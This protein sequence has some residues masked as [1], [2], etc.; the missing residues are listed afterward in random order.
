MA[1]ASV[2]ESKRTEATGEL[3]AL[4]TGIEMTDKQLLKVFHQFNIE[5]Y[6]KIGDKFDPSVHDA[7]FQT[8]D[9]TKEEGTLS[10]VLKTGYRLKSRVIRAAQVG[11]YSKPASP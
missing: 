5:K 10:Q 6:G 8:P 11:A 1:L 3:K 9:A 7:L 2:P 4:Y